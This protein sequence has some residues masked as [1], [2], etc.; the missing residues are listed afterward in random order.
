MPNTTPKFD[1]TG[2]GFKRDPVPTLTRMREAGPL[3]EGRIPLLG[4]VWFATTHNAVTQLLKDTDHFL[5]DARKTGSTRP[6]GLPWWMPKQIRLLADNM[7]T[8]DDPQHRRLRQGVD[9]VFHR[10]NIDRYRPSIERVTDQLLL[11]LET[12]RDRD[13][14]RHVARELP[15][16]VICDLLGLPQQDRPKFTRWMTAMSTLN[17]ATSI[18]WM[19]PAINNL[20]RYLK[21]IF[22]LR[23]REPKD[24]LISALVT[25]DNHDNILTDDELLSMCFILFIAGHETTTHLISGSIL[26]LLQNHNEL[27]K[28]KSD[29]TRAPSAVEELL[30]YVSPVQMSKPRFV[31]THTEFYGT[32]LKRGDR[33]M[34]MI[35]A[36]NFDP[37]MFDSPEKLDLT[38]E[39]NRHVAFGQ[40][41]H[42]C[43]GLQLARME[44]QI[45]LQK[46][47]TK[48]PNV[49]LAIPDEELRWTKRI[50]IRALTT[51]PL[52][53]NG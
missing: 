47:F 26:A 24:D 31:K 3:V 27:E 43:L 38:R 4:T 7:L 28:L 29:W 23:R 49:K 15:L 20:S 8:N 18:F 50:G 34:A 41:P 1:L 44:A 13:V 39:K 37:Q 40:G 22:K 42:L 35:A 52:N 9:R 33:I 30:R 6:M 10:H 16:Y 48:F 51:L 25:Q 53:L 11:T 21:T 36:A 5:V 14:V 32:R 17:S 12:S 45:V 2:Q 46:L 19:I